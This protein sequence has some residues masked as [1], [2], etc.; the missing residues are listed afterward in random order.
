[1]N[2]LDDLLGSLHQE[3]TN[4]LSDQLA[5]LEREVNTRRLVSAET[6]ILL[7]DQITELTRQILLLLPEHEDAPDPH[8]NQRNLLEK[9]RRALE[10]QLRE[11]VRNRWRDIQELQREARSITNELRLARDHYLRSLKDYAA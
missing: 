11:E 10:G 9:E 7:Y 6:T 1:M 4:E 2:N 5:L 8:R 3:K